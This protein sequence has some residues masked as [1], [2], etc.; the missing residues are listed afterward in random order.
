CGCGGFFLTASRLLHQRKGWEYEEI[1][2][3]RVY[4]VDLS[5]GAICQAKLLLDVFLLEEGREPLSSYPL[6]WGDATEEG[7]LGRLRE[8]SREG[9]DW[10]VGNP[11]YVRYQA[12]P[13]EVWEHARAFRTMQDGSPDLY[14]CFFELGLGLLKERG[15]LSYLSPGTYLT[16]TNGRGLRKLIQEGGYGGRVIDFRD[17]PVFGAGGNFPC[18][19]MLKKQGKRAH[20]SYGQVG[21]SD[22]GDSQRISYSDYPLSSFF[23][24][25]RFR[26]FPPTQRE[27]IER[28]EN[29]GRELRRWRMRGGISTLCNDLFIFTPEGEEDGCFLRTLEGVRYRIEKGLCRD[30]LRPSKMRREGSLEEGMEKII[31][32]YTE[33]QGASCLPEEVLKERYPEGYAFLLAHKKT[34]DARERGK[35]SYPAFYAFG[36]AHGLLE[37]GRKLLLPTMGKAPMA[38]PV[39]Q[40]DLLYYNGLGIWE[41][42]ELTLLT[43]QCYLES[44]AFWY[45]LWYTSKPY[46]EGYRS[47]DKRYISGF[48][49]PDLSRKEMEAL[50]FLEEEEREEAIWDSYG[51]APRGQDMRSLGRE[52]RKVFYQGF[53][54]SAGAKQLQL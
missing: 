43:L 23:P 54:E 25:E 45:Y 18:V 53:V 2:S 39:F 21:A 7:V 35:G 33:G 34:L 11:P 52:E 22:L 38:V 1:L 14:L 50:L 51:G 40:R 42:D 20:L 4:G 8:S 12:L 9:F 49:I 16:S 37:Y 44:E 17:M 5:E 32:P 26:F 28:L 41:E 47:F 31:Y 36:R 13:K 15:V 46:R 27:V 48:T 29:A 6:L 24:G 10:V 30:I 19:T 3:R